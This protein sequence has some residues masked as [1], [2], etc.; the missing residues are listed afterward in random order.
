MQY[1]AHAEKQQ[2]I[3]LDDLKLA[4]QARVNTSFTPAPSREVKRRAC[5]VDG[6]A[7]T[8]RRTLVAARASSSL[9]ASLA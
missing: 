7:R 2:T 9:L 4:I 1:A 8:S 5:A 6:A 3:D